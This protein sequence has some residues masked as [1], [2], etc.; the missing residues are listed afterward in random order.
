[1]SSNLHKKTRTIIKGLFYCSNFIYA[2]NLLG[3]KGGGL[4]QQPEIDL[5]LFLIIYKV[6]L[7]SICF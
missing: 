2:I 4:M 6:G 7:Y 3:E 1:M 5:Y